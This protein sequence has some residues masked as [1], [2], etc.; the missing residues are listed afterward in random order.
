MESNNKTELYSLREAY[1]KSL[2]KLGK[3]TDKIVALDADLSKSTKSVYFKENFPERFFEMGIAEQNMVSVAAGLSFV[4]KIPFIH[5]F[6]VF[7]TGRVYDQIR[8][9]V[10][11]PNANVKICG[12]SCGLSDYGDGKTHQSLED[13][14]LMRV[15]P[16]MHVFVPCDAEET[17][18]ITDYM[19]NNPGPMFIRINRNDL[20]IIPGK[21]PFSPGLVYTVY[22]GSD[23]AVICN[24]VMVSKCVEVAELLSNTVSIKVI[25]MPSVKPIDQDSL[26]NEISNCKKVITV[27]EHSIFGGLGSAVAE[28]LSSYGIKIFLLGINDTFGT[29]A[30]GYEELLDHF[31]LSVNKLAE[32]IKQ[33]SE[34]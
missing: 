23:V 16:N 22:H 19:G 25:N 24:G 21:K 11:I 6:A 20:P 34:K 30:R 1:G 18:A 9:S 14:A 4:G 2:V 17:E 5:S 27:E 29:S 10:C 15:L 28:I 7:I 26:I 12:S 13:V 33:I 3:K 8:N 32:K 31:G